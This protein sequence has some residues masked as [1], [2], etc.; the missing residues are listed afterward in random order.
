MRKTLTR[1][2]SALALAALMALASGCAAP[3]VRIAPETA[4]PCASLT[5]VRPS[6]GEIEAL[7]D[8]T[9]SDVDANNVA[10]ARG[11]GRAYPG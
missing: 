7:G 9:A 8:R 6:A 3:P 5:I 1:P 2:C 4:V 11:C 10:I